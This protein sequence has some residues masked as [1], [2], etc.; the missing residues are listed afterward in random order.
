MLRWLWHAVV[1]GVLGC[2]FAVAVA[3]TGWYT[4]SALRT[5]NFVSNWYLKLVRERGVSHRIGNIKVPDLKRPALIREGAGHYA[6]MCS[7]CHLAPGKTDADIRAG[8][9]P[10]PPVLAKIAANLDPRRAFWIIKH[11]IG[12]TAMPAWGPTHDDQ[13]IWAITAFVKDLPNISPAQYKAMTANF[14]DDD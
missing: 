13:K 7:S 6:E 5:S 8:L 1:L 10:R 11:G 3:W 12:F 4:P 9:D 14:K 2:L